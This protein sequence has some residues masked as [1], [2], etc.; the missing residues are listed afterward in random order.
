MYYSGLNT[1]DSANGPGMR[2]SL[3]VS[4]CTL[5]CKGCFNK[6]SWDFNY[7]KEYTKE[8][9]DSIIKALKDPYINGLSILGGDPL[10]PENR[11][12]VL[13]LVQRVRQE[14][15]NK[16]IYLWTGRYLKQVQNLPIM[17][18]LDAVIDGPYIESKHVEGQWY[19]S[20]NQTINFLRI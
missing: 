19:G 15:P 2:V 16:T 18:Y 10:E 4:G 1:C 20:S 8:V 9:E 17:N 12:T 6:Q 3:F 5:K 14:L 11:G 7:G 13:S